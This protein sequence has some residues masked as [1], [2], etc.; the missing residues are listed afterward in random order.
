MVKGTCHDNPDFEENGYDPA[1]ITNEYTTS[2]SLRLAIK[3]NENKIR[4]SGAKEFTALFH[5]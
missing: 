2:L 1:K 3:E 4:P 5:L